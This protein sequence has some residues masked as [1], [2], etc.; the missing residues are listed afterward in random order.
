MSSVG[1]PPE[2]DSQGEVVQKSLVNVTIPSKLANFL[3][4]K[5]INRSKLFTDVVRKMYKKELCPRCYGEVIHKG[6][7]GIWC[8]DCEPAS[9]R[10]QGTF[11]WIHFFNCENCG[12]KYNPPYNMFTQS[13]EILK[14]GFECI[15][16]EERS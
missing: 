7:V 5:G 14:G 3:K 1:R 16:P 6:L 13:K 12:R 9:Y 11:H 8:A 15:P 4:R 10:V 2:L